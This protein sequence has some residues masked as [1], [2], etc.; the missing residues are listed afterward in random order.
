M[1][2]GLSVAYDELM[3]KAERIAAQ[4]LN[5]GCQTHDVIALFAPNSIDWIVVC[6]AAMR[7]G[8]TVAPINSLLAAGVNKA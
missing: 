5:Q 2:S 4:L 3:N 8:A 7:I 1:G 6:L